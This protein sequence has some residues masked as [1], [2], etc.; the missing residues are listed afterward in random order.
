MQKTARRVVVSQPVKQYIVN[1]A[2]AS[3]DQAR[4]TQGISPRGSA[5]MLRACQA[6]AAFASRDFVVPE[7]VQELAPNV[8]GH[9]IVVQAEASP[10]LGRRAI[11]QLLRSVP[12][13]L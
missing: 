7:D 9:R 1:L 6:W 12:V 3:R 4:F 5:A 10:G 2:A 13:P 8:W 11:A